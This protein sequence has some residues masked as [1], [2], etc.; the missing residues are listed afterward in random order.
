MTRLARITAA[1][2]AA[3]ALLAVL[4]QLYVGLE[5]RP[6]R[7]ALEEMWRMARYFTI[8]TTLLVVLRYTRVAALGRA[9]AAWTGAITLWALIVGAVYHGLLARDLTG[10]RMVAD[11]MLHSAVPLFVGLW[12]LAFAPKAALRP[13]HA[14]WW[15]LWPAIYAAYALW[16]GTFVD[17]YPYFF[18]DPT[19]QGWDGVALWLL[20]LGVVFWVAGRGLVALGGWLSRDR[21]HPDNAAPADPRPR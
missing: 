14:T 15:L 17:R 20:G 1:L 18:V 5:R 19:R 6:D 10:L 9:S 4:L 7:T 16:R 13:A 3:T 8:L 2:I 12:W 11:Q 21:P